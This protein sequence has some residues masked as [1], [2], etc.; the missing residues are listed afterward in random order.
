MGRHTIPNNILPNSDETNNEKLLELLSQICDKVKITNVLIMG[1]FNLPATDFS[2]YM[3]DSSK[4]SYA[5]RFFELTQ[6]MFF[7]QIVQQ[8][9]RYMTEQKPSRV[10]NVFLNDDSISAVST[11]NRF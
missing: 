8:N 11:I 3:V 1:D 5:M 6:D 9:T 7:K 10:D 4:E 2:N